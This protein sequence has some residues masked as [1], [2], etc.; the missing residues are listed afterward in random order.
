MGKW[1]KV[2]VNGT[3]IEWR[4]G[5]Y[6]CDNQELLD[7]LRQYFEALKRFHDPVMLDGSVFA[8][9]QG[10]YLEVSWAPAFALL[11]TA[12][13]TMKF[14]DGDRPTWEMFGWKQEEG[15]VT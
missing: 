13:N 12:C 15:T 3:V 6:I 11:Q 1:F 4:D 8:S 5:K 9:C 7:G 10:E 2:D 14:L